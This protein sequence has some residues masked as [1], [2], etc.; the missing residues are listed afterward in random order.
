MCLHSG[1]SAGRPSQSTLCVEALSPGNLSTK[2]VSLASINLTFHAEVP[3]NGTHTVNLHTNSNVGSGTGGM[4][5]QYADGSLVVH[6]VTSENIPGR[7][8][9]VVLAPEFQ[10]NQTVSALVGER[11][12]LDCSGNSLAGL[13]NSDSNVAVAEQVVVPNGTVTFPPG[14]VRTTTTIEISFTVR[15]VLIWLVQATQ[16]LG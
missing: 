5:G 11:S 1:C 2:L 14:E 4:H 10:Q 12:V 9:I 15:K 6:P 16:R 13:V 7:T 3:I 8:V